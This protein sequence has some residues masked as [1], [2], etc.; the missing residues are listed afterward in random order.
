MVIQGEKGRLRPD[1]I[2][3]TQ[4]GEKGGPG[5]PS[6]AQQSNR[7]HLYPWTR[8]V[9]TAKPYWMPQSRQPVKNGLGIR[10]Q[11]GQLGAISSPVL[12]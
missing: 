4:E 9:T 3:G 12:K 8:G 11:G 6:G 7:G 2:K 1:A 10:V 5:A